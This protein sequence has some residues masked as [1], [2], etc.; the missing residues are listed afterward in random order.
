MK[1]SLYELA[2][3]ILA[4]YNVQTEA[5]AY[6]WYDQYLILLDAVGY[7][8]DDYILVVGIDLG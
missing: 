4:I 8:L 1:A 2:D 3:H 6:V 7:A 5:Q